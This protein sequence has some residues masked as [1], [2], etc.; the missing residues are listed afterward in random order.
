MIAQDNVIPIRP[1]VAIDYS[2]ALDPSALVEMFE[3]HADM[4]RRG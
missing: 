3:R 2:K 1:D 4:A